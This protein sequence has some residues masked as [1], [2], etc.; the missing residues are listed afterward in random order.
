MEINKTIFRRYDIRGKYPAELNDSAAYNIALS[1]ANIFPDIKTVVV[2]GDARRS[3]PAVKQS[4]INGLIDGGKEVIDV[5]IVITPIV[6]FA[7]CHFNYEAGIVITGSHLEGIYNGIK[8]V[9]KDAAPTTPSDY[10]KIMNH[11]LDDKM[12]IAKNKGSVRAV[13]AEEEY[14]NYIK[15]KIK[16]KKTLKIVID[17]GNGTAR[18]LPEGIFKELGCEVETIF[19]EPDDTL[20]NHIPDPYKYENMQDLRK[21]VLETGADLGIG[22]DGDGDR[23]GFID[24]SGRFITGDDLLM[25]FSRDALAK[26]KGPIVADSRASMALIE[27]VR[28]Q[29]QEITLTVGYHAAVLAKIIETGAVFGGE[30]T[31]HFY[32]PLEIYL[33]DDAVFAA[34]K[35]AMIASEQDDFVE[36]IENLPRYATSEEIFI[37]FA[38]ETKY[39]VVERFVEMVKKD[40]YDVN[41][42]D[43]A[44]ISY[45]NGWAIVRAANTSPFIKVKFEGKTQA[46]LMAVTKKTIELMERVSIIMPEKEKKK[47]GL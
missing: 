12:G 3:T 38:D 14:C 1:F 43:G 23:V 8:I 35:I 25:V 16:I 36:F 40:G 30:T 37:D 21:R 2:G 45:D 42:V 18:L 24:K 7:V 31:S 10:E 32:F 39:N 44:R 17:T 46:D 19:A 26:K 27:E 34:L 9:L 13:K 33:T 41:D 20:P 6:Y 11:I 15:E 4:V 28:G 5:G 47:L 22:F 29:G